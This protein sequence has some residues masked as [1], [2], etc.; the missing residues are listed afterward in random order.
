MPWGPKGPVLHPQMLS[1]YL[2]SLGCQPRLPSL[3]H[4]RQRMAC[5]VSPEQV[6]AKEEESGHPNEGCLTNS[7][8]GDHFLWC[9]CDKCCKLMP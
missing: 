4:V 6:W 5:L 3:V 8:Y 7:I 9:F 1:F 2:R